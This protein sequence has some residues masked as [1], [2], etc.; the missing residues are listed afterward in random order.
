MI[1]IEVIGADRVASS[2]SGQI[3]KVRAAS[4]SS[5]GAWA[6]S[7]ADYIKKSKLSGDPLHRRTGR[8]SRSI[9]PY[10]ES[11][12]DTVQS[13]AGGGRGVPYAKIHEFGGVINHPG[14]T[15]YFVPKGGRAVFVSNASALAATLPRTRPHPI[16]MP[17]R[18][19]MRSAFEERAPTGIEQLRAAVKAAIAA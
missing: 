16:P 5:L 19:Y 4:E 3:A 13:G 15:A 14:G 9:R 11:A 10:F 17:E 2:L 12:G 18:S 7:L 1:Q 6:R 8:L